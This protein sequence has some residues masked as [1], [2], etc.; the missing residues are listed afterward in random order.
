M[1]LTCAFV[2]L[3]ILLAAGVDVNA[4]T[5]E[6]IQLEAIDEGR[7][8]HPLLPNG[9]D[10]WYVGGSKD[11]PNGVYS[12]QFY[13][14]QVDSAGTSLNNFHFDSTG[15]VRSIVTDLW[16]D[17]D[18]Q[19]HAFGYGSHAASEFFASCELIH[20]IL[21]TDLEVIS[22][23]RKSISEI[24]EVYAV[25]STTDNS[26]DLFITGFAKPNRGTPKGITKRVTATLD[27]I[28]STGPLT[29]P[30]SQGSNTIFPPSSNVWQLGS[31]I[32][33]NLNSNFIVEASAQ[34]GSII[35][36]YEMPIY[37]SNPS[38]F[39]HNNQVYVAGARNN[40]GDS[41]YIFRRNGD[42]FE[43]ILGIEGES[44]LSIGN[45]RHCEVIGDNFYWARATDIVTYQ[46]TYDIMENTGSTTRS[47]V[48][49][50][51]VDF[52]CK[53][54]RQPY[55]QR[56]KVVNG[57]VCTIIPGRSQRGFVHAVHAIPA[58]A[59]FDS[60]EVILSIYENDSYKVA[61]I[62][63]VFTQPNQDVSIIVRRAT[64]TLIDNSSQFSVLHVS[65]LGEI[66]GEYPIQGFT[67]TSRVRAGCIPHDD[68]TAVFAVR[69]PGNNGSSDTLILT[70]IDKFGHVLAQHTEL[71]QPYRYPYSTIL[72]PAGSNTFYIFHRFSDSV[73]L[74]TRNIETLTLQQTVHLQNY[75]SLLTTFS[76]YAV[77]LDGNIWLGDPNPAQFVG[78]SRVI[79]YKPDGSLRS[80]TL[81]TPENI[82]EL[83]VSATTGYLYAAG[84]IRAP[85]LLDS[86]GLRRLDGPQLIMPVDRNTGFRSVR[87]F[88]SVYQYRNRVPWHTPSGSRTVDSLTGRRATG[89]GYYS[90]DS[91]TARLFITP[92]QSS[93]ILDVAY[94]HFADDFF[95][96]LGSSTWET[97]R[98][99]IMLKTPTSSVSSITEDHYRT[100][101]RLHPNPCADFVNVETTG[102]Q[103]NNVHYE[104]INSRGQVVR[105]QNPLTTPVT[106]EDF[107]P[108]LYY[109]RI[110]DGSTFET[111]PLLIQR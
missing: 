75:D 41:I 54:L 18:G 17:R 68:G 93:R 15:L 66:L 51:F 73:W 47:R 21:S 23:Y 36:Y 106:L 107:S 85:T 102:E 83:N 99:L 53:P 84:T 110:F 111:Q 30:G 64:C 81:T 45:P 98:Q 96:V 25:D 57:S 8:L 16:L 20:V 94:V 35:D 90:V 91:V 4:Q 59:N 108:G 88:S 2:T 10:G 76:D 82:S 71:N 44:H 70:R 63:G 37:V 33:Y 46:F 87:D 80:D 6:E 34:T 78:V 5:V 27:E 95:Y 26:N 22:I 9:R 62:A 39:I 1:K 72:E 43:Q 74:S 97:G 14:E 38:V 29:H 92:D 58:P 89:F 103:E 49:I 32:Y 105:S 77:D 104:I 50:P 7:V 48:S 67:K 13:V 65:R 86:L 31:S 79:S 52:S 61:S 101:W 19:L 60:T 40:G 3:L 109:I 12:P 56:F 69:G 55:L 28:W 11:S 100:D 42:E 24:T